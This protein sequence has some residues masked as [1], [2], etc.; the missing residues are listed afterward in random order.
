MPSLDW[1]NA[2]FDTLGE[3]TLALDSAF[4]LTAINRAAESLYGV[5]REWAIG[6]M[7]NE[8]IGEDLGG[9]FSGAN[10]EHALIEAWNAV[11]RGETWRGLV[12][13]TAPGGRRFR[14]ELSVRGV[15]TST[16]SL[17][18]TL[19]GLIA[20]VRDVTVREAEVLRR[21][22]LSDSLNALANAHTPEAVRH[23]ALNALTSQGGADAAILRERQPEGFQL[24]A[25]HGLSD[26]LLELGRVV[27]PTPNELERLAAGEVLI[28]VLPEGASGPFPR[29]LSEHGFH[30]IVSVGQRVGG[31]LI[32]TIVLIYKGVPQVD[33]GPVLPSLGAALGNQLQE[34]R[35][36]VAL[37]HRARLLELLNRIDHLVLENTPMRPML[38]ALAVG[39]RGL[40]G[41][42]WASV[43][44]APKDL[45]EITWLARVGPPGE[46]IPP[47]TR[48]TE[49]VPAVLEG[50]VADA[51][52]SGQITHFG[53]PTRF[54]LYAP[55]G[56]PD[57]TLVLSLVD[58]IGAFSSEDQRN[59]SLIVTQFALAFRRVRDRERFE[60][61]RLGLEALVEATRTLRT[62]ETESE[63]DQIAVTH[64]LGVTRADTASLLMLEPSADLQP[65]HDQLRVVA[66]AGGNTAGL[67]GTVQKRDHGL[68]WRVIDGG[69]ARI[70]YAIEPNA[71]LRTPSGTVFSDMQTTAIPSVQTT[72]LC[73]PIRVTENHE[74]RIVGVLHADAQ[75]RNQAFDEN[76]TARLTAVAEA[77]GSARARL[78]AL[79]QAKE[80]AS[81]FERLAKLSSSLE[82]L[83]RPQD[84]AREGLR[85]LLDLTGFTAGVY[86]II[87]S[88][89]VR[90]TQVEGISLEALEPMRTAFEVAP[91]VGLF[92][93]ATL[94][95]GPL[96]ITDYQQ[97]PSP[98]ASFL[99]V[100]LR[101]IV[102]TPVY[103]NGQVQ[104]FLGVGSFQAPKPLTPSTAEIVEFLA[105][106]LSRALERAAQI[107]EITVSEAI[108]IHALDQA[109]ERATAFTQLAAL[110]AELEALESPRT[111]ARRGLETLLAL[112]GLDGAIY[113]EI[114]DGHV[115]VLDQHGI[116]PTQVIEWYDGNPVDEWAD[117]G[118]LQALFTPE[119]LVIENY[120]TREGGVVGFRD[121]G[122]TTFVIASIRIQDRPQGFVA[123][124][125]FERR[126]PLPEGVSGFVQFLT[127][128]ISRALERA[129]HLGEVLLSETVALRALSQAEERAR[130]FIQL[131][132]LSADLEAMEDPSDIAQRALE[133]LIDLTELEC[134]AYV[135]LERNRVNVVEQRGQFPV[136]F[137]DAYD[138][139]DVFAWGGELI[140]ER[141]RSTEGVFAVSDVR[142]L[143]EL[144]EGPAAAGV[145][146]VVM[147]PVRI[148]QVFVGYVAA[149]SFNQPRVLPPGT[150]E[151]TRFIGQRIARALER[152]AQTTELR[153]A[154]SAALESRDQAA[155]RA[156]AFEQLA[157]LSAR[158]ESM[159]ELRTIAGDGLET[160]LELTG[161]DAGAYYETTDGRLNPIEMRGEIPPILSTLSEKIT[162]PNVSGVFAEMIRSGQPVI[163][164]DYRDS[165]HPNPDFVKIGV[166]TVVIAPVRFGGQMRGFISA[167][168]YGVPCALPNGTMELVEFISARISRA[169]ERADQ[170]A[171]ILAMR[172]SSFQ[173]LTRTLEARDVET[174]GHT[175]RVTQ[176]ALSLGRELKL[177]RANLQWLEWGAY[178][179]DIGKVAIP[180]AIL[181]KPGPLTPQ[182]WKVVKEHP[183]IG[184]GI[185]EDLHFLPLETLQIVRYHQ[186]RSD[187]SGYP[188]GLY[189]PEIPYLA[190]LFAVVDVYDALIS[191]RPYKPPWMH[192]DAIAELEHQAGQTLDAEIVTAFT[193]M[194]Q[195]QRGG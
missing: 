117:L 71:V 48:P 113:A 73:V 159:D 162:T 188:D 62:A 174:R 36:R 16:S 78:Q 119:P 31:N 125:S 53:G 146:S 164:P 157:E 132:Q 92:G 89:R 13:H 102:L 15:L 106:R 191:T 187:G 5:T 4:R 52:S 56:L 182:E 144:Q 156:R 81:A 111:I 14:A 91:Q 123:A 51:V 54:G 152:I 68:A 22:I 79:G 32:G 80:R 17:D 128:R 141:F 124:A 39:L 63:L 45:R 42:Q 161:L 192:S 72:A 165:A 47:V 180:D 64:A 65:D 145:R 122:I 151:I 181:H 116:V 109:E 150:S 178:L 90:V 158:L 190:R 12:W 167:A 163:V 114:T 154:E 176:N 82:K 38:E 1:S 33:L 59:A 43:G 70:E 155:S 140:R 115:R 149:V 49:N 24:V 134:A 83:D 147:A 168:S 30:Q 96:I 110:S 9:Q 27:E 143:P 97:R 120:L 126:Q 60:Y 94:H 172:A 112:T 169:L 177:D 130:A 108:A 171:E 131:A 184:Y 8:L 129:A 44:F 118:L 86:A 127:G 18:G 93:E 98:D 74:S 136:G 76:D 121:L 173:A 21:T 40:F 46:S 11:Q 7:L 58:H 77:V 107:Q 84:I 69:E 193:R 95:G 179:H 75:T 41:V 137:L 2:L 135:K 57:G 55:M 170:V 37:E 85:A 29:L 34:T 99:A 175:D 195:R 87:E 25:A 194:L 142:E 186:E 88:G 10:A 66:G 185:L 148:G 166:R 61:E 139:S 183:I 153:N 133:T 6:R 104:G 103:L 105:G 3:A 101:S 28:S 20:V 189:G 50:R 138:G 26:D 160:L 100:G 35:G 23:A 67:V 19:E